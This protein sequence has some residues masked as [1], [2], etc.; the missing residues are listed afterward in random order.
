MPLYDPR[1]GLDVDASYPGSFCLMVGVR[2]GTS[3]H[4]GED[5]TQSQ[6]QLQVEGV[7][8]WKGKISPH[9]FLMTESQGE[10]C[11]ALSSH[12]YKPNSLLRA[13]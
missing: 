1:K 2:S 9:S 8:T 3:S 13:P 6:I 11:R 4:P 10:A 7:N 5:A 12:P